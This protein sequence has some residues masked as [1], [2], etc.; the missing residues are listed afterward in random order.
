MSNQ[1]PQQRGTADT[2]MQEGAATKKKD[3]KV[4]NA[5]GEFCREVEFQRGASLFFE[6]F[7]L[8]PAEASLAYSEKSARYTR[9]SRSSSQFRE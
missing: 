8:F 5:K 1:E 2:D 6:A 7:G 9:T 4:M 3:E